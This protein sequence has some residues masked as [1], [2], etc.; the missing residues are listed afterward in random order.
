MN[1]PGQTEEYVDSFDNRLENRGLENS[2]IDQGP[3]WA[4][5]SMTPSRM[6]KGFTAEGGIRSPLIVKLPGEMASAGSINQSFL[7][8]RDIMPTILDAAG[9]KP[10]G[11]QFAGRPVQP[12]QGNSVLPMLEGREAGTAPGVNQVGY[13][14]F[15]MKAFFEGDWKALW[16]PPPNGPGEWELFDLKQDPGELN[17]LGKKHP[18]KLEELVTRWEQYEKENGVLDLSSGGGA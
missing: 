14:L 15:G 10:P 11:E 16:M 8:I 7:H 2:L 9:I 3:G 18:Q 12:I 17:D 4:Q 13:E 6:Y 1:Y 5:A